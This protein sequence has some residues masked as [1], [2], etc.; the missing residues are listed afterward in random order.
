MKELQSSS[1]FLARP[2]AEQSVSAI[3]NYI[4]T[5]YVESVEKQKKCQEY[6]MISHYCTHIH[7]KK[8]QK[9]GVTLARLHRNYN[10]GI[11]GK[12]YSCNF[13]YISQCESQQDLL[14]L[15]LRHQGMPEKYIRLFRVKG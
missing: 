1:D 9:Q 12:R 7:K 8:M 3:K 13:S 14:H 10:F 2:F 11:G 5:D 15:C 6:R 4:K